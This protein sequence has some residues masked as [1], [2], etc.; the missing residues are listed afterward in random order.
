M[1]LS[2]II[3]LITDYHKNEV[4]SLAKYVLNGVLIILVLV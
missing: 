1:W 3:K 2:Q 4:F